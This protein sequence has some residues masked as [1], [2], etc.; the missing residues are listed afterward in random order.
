MRKGHQAIDKTKETISEAKQ[1]FSKKKEQ[2]VDKVFP[3]Y[4]NGKPDTENN[5]KRFKEHLQADVSDDVKN[6]FAY[7]DFIGIDYKVLISFTCDTTTIN[8]I[9]RTKQMSLS[10]IDYDDG[11]SFSAEFPWWDKE[12]ISKIKPYKTGKEYEYWEYLWYDIQTRQ[13]YYL[14]FS[15]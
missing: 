14:E 8:K 7:G 13:A 5:K 9:I 10:T 1:N 15:L 11:L 12:R 4:D 6:I 2:L 3:S